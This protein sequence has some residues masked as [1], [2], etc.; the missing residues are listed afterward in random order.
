[1]RVYKL[2]VFLNKSASDVCQLY[3][4]LKK[5]SASMLYKPYPCGFTSFRVVQA[6]S[7]RVCK[8]L[9]FLN[10]SASDLK[11]LPL[12]YPLSMRV[13][14]LP[15]SA[16]LSI[17]LSTGPIHAGFRDTYMTVYGRLHDGTFIASQSRV[18]NTILS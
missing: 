5:I 15:K 18:H 3:F 6:L 10:K 8:L 7:M 17:N 11:M 2:L 13:Y 14:K 16:S 1:M 9:I 12:V 4:S